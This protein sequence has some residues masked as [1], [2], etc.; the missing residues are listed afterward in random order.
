M[1]LQVL[2]ST[3]TA[4]EEVFGC[5]NLGVAA[6]VQLVRMIVHHKSQIA[7]SDATACNALN[8]EAFL[9]CRNFN[10]AV[11]PSSLTVSSLNETSSLSLTSFE[12]VEPFV[13]VEDSPEASRW[14]ALTAYTVGDLD[15]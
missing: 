15:A 5:Q 9:V 1:R 2:G 8:T 14:R 12:E 11:V 3:L 6:R 10:P 4:G 13:E 7:I